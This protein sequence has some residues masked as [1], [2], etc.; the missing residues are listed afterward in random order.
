MEVREMTDSKKDQLREAFAQFVE[1]QT[2]GMTPAAT[3]EAAS[4]CL[5]MMAKS[6][7]VALT[8][9]SLPELILSE[10]R[11][12]RIVDH[13]VREGRKYM[14]AHLQRRATQS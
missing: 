7:T 4:F 5:G 1:D 11:S 6:T 8:P 9:D 13:G 10:D 3:L 12:Q 14:T 2:I